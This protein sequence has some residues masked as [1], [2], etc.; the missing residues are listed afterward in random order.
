DE[1]EGIGFERADRMAESLGIA[2]NSMERIKSGIRYVLVQNGMQNGHVCLPESKLVAVA[3]RLLGVTEDECRAALSEL[4]TAQSVDVEI[5]GGV[6]YLYDH[7]AYAAEGYIAKKLVLLDKLCPAVDASDVAL[8]IRREEREN[9]VEYANLQ[10]KAIYDALSSG[11]MILTGGPG[12]GKTT[13]VRALL[14]IF[15]E[16]GMKVA[17]CAPTGRAAKRLSEST[18]EEAKTIHRLLEMGVDRKNASGQRDDGRVVFGRDE[19]NLLEENVIIVDESSMIDNALMCALL[20]AVKPGARLILIGDADQLPSVGAGNVLSDLIAS[21][22]F[23][24]VRLTEIFRQAGESLIITNAHAIN[25]GRMPDLKAKNNDFFFLPRETDAQIA[26]TVADL[27]KTRLPRA[28]GAEIIGGI[29]ILAPSRKGESGTDAL[30]VLLQRELNPPARG[31]NEYAYRDRVYRE[32]DRVMQIRNNYDIYWEKSDTD[33]TGIFNGDI[34][35]IQKIDPSEQMMEI[36]FDDRLAEYDFS[37]LDELD[38]AYAI[39]VHKSQ[40]SEYPT[41]ILP[42][43]SAPPMLLTRNLLYTAVTRASARVIIVGRIEVIETMVGNNR[44]SMRYTGLCRRVK[45]AE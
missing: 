42:A 24:T 15:S 5:D 6:R 36:L 16:I 3:A 34:G 37:L 41:V 40:G 21:E 23:S 1:I 9:G 43:Y 2:H 39:T 4:I 25:G 30:N 27:C 12:T 28:Y 17:L 14:R 29:Q 33:G 22:R 19:K 45:R 11:V 10:K 7:F 13:I 20:K 32:G 31:K 26:A 8:F 18:S 38:H 44:E 35:I